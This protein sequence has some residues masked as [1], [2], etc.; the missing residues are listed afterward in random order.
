MQLLLDFKNHFSTSKKEMYK[1]ITKILNENEELR[2]ENNNFKNDYLYTE[3]QI[4]KEENERLSDLCHDLT[5]ENSLM[6]NYIK[7]L[8]T[9]LEH[10]YKIQSKEQEK[11]QDAMLYGEDNPYYLKKYSPK[12]Y[13]EIL[14]NQELEKVNET[15]W[16]EHLKSN[17]ENL[18]LAG[19]NF[20]LTIKNEKLQEEN[21][22]LEA[23]NKELKTENS[24]LENS[25]FKL[26]KE[27]EILNID[28]PLEED[29]Y[30]TKDLENNLLINTID[31]IT[32]ERNTYKE[33]IDVMCD[34]FEISKDAVL[35]ILDDIQINK[36]QQ[37][38]K[39]L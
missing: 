34:K 32:D 3:N 8:E 27:K 39:T 20:D 25:Y 7:D 23:E 29:Y 11:L 31:K 6:D 4:L 13:K 15:L 19:E 24:R 21:R 17:T 35:D 28:K 36:G 37:I 16:Q 38:E 9:N 26:K 33:I 18:N 10:Y 14:R 1:L 30:N 22:D 2:E 5:T 12:L